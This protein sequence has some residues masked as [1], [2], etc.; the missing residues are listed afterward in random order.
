M[1]EFIVVIADES[2]ELTILGA[3][4][5]RAEADQFATDYEK[6]WGTRPFVYKREAA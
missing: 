6:D 1:F 4:N 3:Y 5:D 2:G